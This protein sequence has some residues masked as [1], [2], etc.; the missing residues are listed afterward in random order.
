MILGVG[1]DLVD[2]RRIEESIRKF[3]HKFLDRIFTAD[4]QSHAFKAAKPHLSFAKRFAAKEAVAKALGTGVRGFLFVDIEVFSDALGKPHVVLHAG[5]AG[6]LR[7]K[8]SEHH[9]A[10]IHLSLSDEDPYATAYA[11]I[12]TT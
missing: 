9:T 1:I 10:H 6:V 3:G 4:E 7:G 12:E 11:V 8:L 2:A 5:A